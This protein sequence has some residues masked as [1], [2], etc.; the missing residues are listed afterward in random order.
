MAALRTDCATRIMRSARVI[1]GM[2]IL[3]GIV[4]N[5]MKLLGMLSGEWTSTQFLLK[6]S[7]MLYGSQC[8]CIRYAASE[9]VKILIYEA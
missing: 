1:G 2:L 9:C 7:Y 3:G 6:L 8:V 5:S 4:V